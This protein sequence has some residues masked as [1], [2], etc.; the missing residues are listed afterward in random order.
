MVSHPE[1]DILDCEV[2]C[3]VIHTEIKKKK[4]KRNTDFNRAVDVMKLQH[5]YSDP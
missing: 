1:S 3:E 2:K 4:G 5:N